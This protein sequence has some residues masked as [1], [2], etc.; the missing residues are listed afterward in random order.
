MS[1][2]FSIFTALACAVAT[3]AIAQ[4]T[5][6]A[7]PPD[8]AA[9]EKQ[10]SDTITVGAA[11]VSIPDYEGS[12]DSR[13]TGAP[14]AIGSYKGFGFVLAG[15]RL[16][17]DLIPDRGGEGIDFQA[18]PIA[19]V[20][21]N[22]SSLNSID[23]PRIRALGK[24][25]TA[26]ELG[27]YVGVGKTGV[28]TSPYDRLS[29]SLSYRHDVAGAH[30]S[31]IWQPTVNYLTPLSRKAAVALFASA[32]H[33]D[34]GYAD[35]YFTVTSTQ[36]VASGLPAY[37]ARSGWKNYTLGALGTYALT[38]DLLHGWKVVAGGTYGRLLN[39]FGDSPVVSIA[40]S[41]SQWLGALGLAYTF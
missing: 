14:G 32:E 17:V 36:A 20:N 27:G 40:G 24:V 1:I 11:I 3:P 16:S 15:N 10:F 37:R 5:V 26:I 23:D 19:V 25:D 35:T 31:G 22:R 7:T 12:D 41:R 38:G 13:I 2:R 9:P 39:D 21:F 28:I 33:A 18:G 4:N 8:T 29:V 30:D 6:N 34:S